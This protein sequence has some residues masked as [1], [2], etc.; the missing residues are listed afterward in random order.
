MLIGDAPVPRLANEK[1]VPLEDPG[2]DHGVAAR[3]KRRSR[4]GSGIRVECRDR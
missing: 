2:V 4:R 3:H 1:E